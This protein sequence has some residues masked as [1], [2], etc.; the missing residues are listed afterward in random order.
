MKISYRK[1]I[2]GG[3]GIM[4][5]A[6]FCSSEQLILQIVSNKMNSTSYCKMLETSLLAFT[7]DKSNNINDVDSNLNYIF[8]QDNAP[9][10]PARATK[11]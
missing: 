5:W 6:S 3:G 9:C 8:Q 2:Q 1:R 4:V 7:E 10:Q 11:I